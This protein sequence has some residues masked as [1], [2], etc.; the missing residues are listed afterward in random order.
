MLFTAINN[1]YDLG[2]F[3]FGGTYAFSRNGLEKLRENKLLPMKNVLGADL[4]EDHFFSMLMVAVGMGLGDLASGDK[5]FACAWKGLPASPETILN[6][7]KK[8][9][10]STRYW[11]EIKEDEIRKFF[12]ETRQMKSSQT[13]VVVSIG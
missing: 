5:P 2:E 11:G 1:G 9:I 10:H 3:V 8:I 13:N 7:N 4:E 12:R 6:A